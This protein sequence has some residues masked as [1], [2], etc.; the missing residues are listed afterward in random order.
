MSNTAI[1]YLADAWIYSCTHERVFERVI[2]RRRI[3]QVTILK[4]L[5]S[6]KSMC[7]AA[8][9][10]RSRPLIVKMSERWGDT[11]TYISI[12][13]RVLLPRLRGT[14][15]PTLSSL[16]YK[17]N[18]NNQQWERPL[19]DYDRIA[20]DMWDQWV[21]QYHSSDGRTDGRF[22]GYPWQATTCQLFPGWYRRYR[23]RQVTVSW[24]RVS[25]LKVVSSEH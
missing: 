4:P 9:N 14:R 2:I 24:Y 19:A 3:L 15:L 6:R 22:S 5:G 8:C 25:A 10:R 20:W 17:C 23:Y 18:F 12:D 11:F 13:E 7:H 21:Y 1:T 16:Q